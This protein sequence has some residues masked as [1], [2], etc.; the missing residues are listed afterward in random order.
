MIVKI[1]GPGCRNCHSLES[2][3]PEFQKPRARK[4][5]MNAIT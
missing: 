5:H 1:L 2:M 4:Q 3:N